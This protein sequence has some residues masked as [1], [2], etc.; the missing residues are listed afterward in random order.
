M[1]LDHSHRSSDIDEILQRL[2]QSIEAEIAQDIKLR[3]HV[4]SVGTNYREVN[5]FGDLVFGMSVGFGPDAVDY[6]YST[7]RLLQRVALN[8]AEKQGWKLPVK[9]VVMAH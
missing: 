3:S 2:N 1:I 5:A 4:I 6:Y 9:T 7:S 8:T